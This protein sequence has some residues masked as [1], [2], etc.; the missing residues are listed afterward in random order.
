MPGF[1]FDD[2][3]EEIVRALCEALVPGSAA[4]GPA[5]YV[6]SVA[7]EMPAEERSALLRA[8]AALEP[9]RSR[10]AEFLAE[11]RDSPEFAQLRALAID[12]YYSDFTEPGYEGPSAW[13]AIDFNSPQARRLRKDWSFLRC[14]R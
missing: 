8:V 13:D 7:A 9:V 5:V 4:V 12:A 11:V 6:D 1:V 3:Q 2:E 10:G 14:Y